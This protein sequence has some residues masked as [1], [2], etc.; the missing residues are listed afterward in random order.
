MNIT[1]TITKDAEIR[2]T[3]RGKKYVNFNVAVNDSYRNREGQRVKHTAFFNCTYWISTGIASLLTKGRAVEL[4]GLLNA[5]AWK[6]KQGELKASMNLNT[7]EIKLVGSGKQADNQTQL[8]VVATTDLD[9]E[10]LPF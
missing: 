8:P 10:H 9:A 5:S 4:I 1:G 2:T 7:S 3:T 6:D